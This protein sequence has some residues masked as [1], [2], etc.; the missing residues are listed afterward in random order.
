MARHGTNHPGQIALI[1][2]VG[3]I[4]IGGFALLFVINP[5]WQVRG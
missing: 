1:L 4:L 2:V 5:T 3:A